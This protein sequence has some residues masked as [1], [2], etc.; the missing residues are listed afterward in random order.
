MDIFL[1]NNDR[2]PMPLWN[3]ED[4]NIE[5]LILKIN[6]DNSYEDFYAID[7]LVILKAMGNN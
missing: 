2:Y 7:S 4:G 1:N 3:C 5:N 6:K